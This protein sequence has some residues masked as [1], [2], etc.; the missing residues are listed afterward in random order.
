MCSKW[1]VLPYFPYLR[2]LKSWI[3]HAICPPFF[4]IKKERKSWIV[5]ELFWV[6]SASDNSRILKCFYKPFFTLKFSFSE[7]KFKK[8]VINNLCHYILQEYLDYCNDMLIV[9]SESEPRGLDYRSILFFPHFLSLFSFL[10][11]LFSF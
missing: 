2:L 1:N 7:L 11:F 5:S 10:S 3:G 4:W 8:K 6:F 9:L